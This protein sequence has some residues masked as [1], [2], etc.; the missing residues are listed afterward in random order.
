MSHL[1]ILGRQP[2]LGLAEL[3]SLLGAPAL[4]P[5]GPQAV[6]TSEE[7]D[8]NRLG[9]SIKMATVIETLSVTDWP[10]IEKYAKTK[11]AKQIDLPPEG[12]LQ[13]GVSLYG[14]KVSPAQVGSLGLSLKK[15]FK[16]SAR[17]VVPQG[18]TYLNSAQVVGNKLTGP[19]G[20]EIVFYAHDGQ[21]VVAVTKAEQD[22]NAYTRRDQARPKRDT[23]V[24][25]LPPKLAQIIINLAGPGK[26]LLDPFCGTG[27]VLQEALLLGYDVYG[28]DLEPRM[29]DY[30][31]ENL[32][33]LADRHE[34]T[35]NITLEVGDATSHQ[36]QPPIDV[37][38]AEGY[39]GRP[40]T[41]Q[42]TGQQLTEVVSTCNVITKK[43]LRNIYDQL[44]PGTRLCLALPAWQVQ[45]GRFKRLPMLDLLEE[46][47]Y[48]RV[49]F[50]HAGA[51][52]LIYYRPDQVVARELVVITRK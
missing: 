27:V 29:I 30:T 50:E 23:K 15:S 2:A 36:W 4:T 46:I 51:D 18:D 48:N 45:S 35:G 24:G 19:Q 12:K 49:E 17:V 38:A 1:L 34:I 40:F 11:L 10:A 39:L 33:W 14:I 7:P 25:M 37:V 26:R 9:G 8:F 21:T 52:D 47:G 28:T 3:E 16:R 41:I 43:F 22:I 6:I 5:F 13:L 44:Q 20:R 42:P 32:D 31:R